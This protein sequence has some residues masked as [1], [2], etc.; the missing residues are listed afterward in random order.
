MAVC[1]A[2]DLSAD[3]VLL[4]PSQL[5]LLGSYFLH[6]VCLQGLNNFLSI[7]FLAK[8]PQDFLMHSALQPLSVPRSF[9]LFLTLFLLSIYVPIF[10]TGFSLLTDLSREDFL[11][12]MPHL[13][14]FF[15]ATTILKK[16]S[17]IQHAEGQETI[18]D[19]E[20]TCVIF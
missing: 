18:L 7:G 19:S 14:L 5:Y 9:F 10:S 8:K 4:W 11:Q 2:E 1:F 3:F 6:S 13:V 17:K 16:P 15:V 12:H 20:R